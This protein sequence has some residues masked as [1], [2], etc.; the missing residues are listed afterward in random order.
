MAKSMKKM[1]YKKE[2][3]LVKILRT[4]VKILREFPLK[5]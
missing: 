3:V 4:L 2:R 5:K 1:S